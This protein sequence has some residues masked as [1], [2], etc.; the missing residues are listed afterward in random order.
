MEIF[1]IQSD[2][3][4]AQKLFKEEKEIRDRVGQKEFE[5]LK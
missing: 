1:F 4:L 5:K 2:F 3:S